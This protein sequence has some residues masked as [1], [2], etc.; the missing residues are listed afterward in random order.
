MIKR[1]LYHFHFCCGL[2]GG[3][4][5]FNRARPRVGNV[6]AEW[7]C[8]GGIDVDPAGLRDFERLAGVPG[9]LL[10]LFTR[11]QYIRFHG[12][13]PPA[14]WREATPED[15]RRA[16]GG[17]RP[18]AVF[19]SSPCKGASG[20]L[21]EKMSL[22]PKY[23]ALNEL[24][25]RCI[26]L[27]GEAWA[28]DPVPLI[29]FENVPRLA[30]RGRHLL[31]QINSLLGG[32]GY[33]V[34]ETTH[35]CGELGGLAQSRKRFLL[36]ARHVEKVPPFLYEPEK[37][38]LRAVGDILGRMPLPGDID[39]AGPMH[40]I[41]SLHWKTWVR[42]ALVEAGSDWRS[43]NKLAIEDGHLRD[44]VIVPEYRSGYMGVHG[45]DDT[46][47]TIAGRS[48][49]TNGAFSVADPRY[50]QAANWN[51][52]QQF[53]VIRWAESAP[54]I[55]GQ[56]MPGQ[57]TFSVA[58]PRPG[59]VRHN[60]VFRVVSMG[61]HA[62]TVTGG[63]SPSSGG[64]AV[65]DPRYHNW[66]PGASSRK[67]H[68][69]EWGSATGTVTGSQQV[70]SGALSIADPRVLDRTKGDA[71][72]TG[73]HYGVVGFDQSAGAVSAS[74]RHDNG[75]WSV[76]DPRMPAANDRLTCI[77]QSLDGTWHR[78]FTTLE[79][80]ALQSLVDPEEQ[81]ILDGLSDSDWRERIGNAVPPAAAEAIAGVMGTTLLLAEAGE[82]FMLSNTPIWVRPVAVALSVAQQEV[83][84]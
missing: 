75:R 16:A 13:E 6:E 80:A 45:W 58:D 77:I 50:R 33:A 72:L 46:A 17:R 7:V 71:Y 63:H 40:R 24:T 32:F 66:H 12:K 78:P 30:S 52:G 26:W 44:L 56:T 53:G 74:A 61:S 48:G 83:N 36:V 76:A 62:G 3:A 14:G 57:G 51:H 60:N 65:A 34:A 20:L 15:I 1:T 22:T 54:T 42:L 9:T 35:D 79:L 8:L 73:G 38:S 27:M 81:L 41:P 18:D 10:D 4:A 2:G 82:T 25:L 43:L 23:Q 29:V 49:P 39:A 69:G 28:D 59:G 64:Q 68:V 21:S 84:P 11:D 19:I 5:G 67:L 55:P 70:A 37:K 31:D 47:S